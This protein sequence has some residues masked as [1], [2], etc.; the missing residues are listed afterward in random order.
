MDE[1]LHSGTRLRGCYLHLQCKNSE[2]RQKR[3]ST[4]EGRALIR[5]YEDYRRYLQADRIALGVRSRWA[6]LYDE[7]LQFQRLLR[8]VEFLTNCKKNSVRRII[9]VYRFRKISIR[10]GFS[11]PINVF[12]P[13]LAILHYG[14]IVVNSGAR[15]GSNCRIHTGVNIGAQLGKG[16]DVPKIGNNCYIG[17]GAKIFG[18]VEIGDN[19]AIGA[20]AVVNKSFPDGNVTL[21]GIP[22]RVISEKSTSGLFIHG[23]NS[24]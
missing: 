18:G 8:K 15:I 9:A 21:G 5:S 12:G 16:S 1:D 3:M 24:V 20:N 22:A 4:V 7:I 19:T 17:P 11:I 23:D 10:L 14:T 13:G 6:F 2:L